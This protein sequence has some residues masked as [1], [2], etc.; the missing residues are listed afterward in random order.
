M[1]GPSPKSG[2]CLVSCIPPDLSRHLHASDPPLEDPLSS[3][4]RPYPFTT[5]LSKITSFK[6]RICDR[7]TG[8]IVTLEDD[9][10]GEHPSFICG[11]CFTMLH[12]D[13]P[14]QH[15]KVVPTLVEY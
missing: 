14:D 5:F 11:G 6:C 2:T 12:D 8:S 1:S 9:L 13:N 15:V 7:D 3:S 10:T 4:T